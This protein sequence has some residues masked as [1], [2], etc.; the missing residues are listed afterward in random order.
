[1]NTLLLLAA[2]CTAPINQ[3]VGVVTSSYGWRILAGKS[4][5]TVHAGIDIRA[6][7]GTPVHAVRLGRITFAR[8]DDRGGGLM[9]DITSRYK[10]K[11]LVTRYA[12][13]SKVAVRVGM[14]VK[15]NHLIGWVGSTGNSS[16]P[17][18]HFEVL[19]KRPG[20]TDLYKDPNPFVCQYRSDIVFPHFKFQR[21]IKISK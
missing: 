14:P 19:I 20:N 18:L 11:I 13:L 16:G 1:M 17:H 6:P 15:A 7:I 2:T 4:E 9:V 21:R 5:K 10:G 12:H 8:W 3:D